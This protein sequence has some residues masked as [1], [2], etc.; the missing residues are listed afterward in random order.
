MK[1]GVIFSLFGS[2]DHYL[3]GLKQ[4][5]AVMQDIYPDSTMIVHTD[6]PERVAEALPEVEIE[7]HSHSKELAGAFW[8]FLSYNDPRFDAV[9]FRDAD[10]VVN[11]REAAAV[12]GWLASGLPLHTMLDHSCHLSGEWPVMAGMWAARKGGIPFDFNYLVKW[13]ISKKDSFQYTSDQWF[14]R[15]YIWPLIASGDGLLHC[16]EFHSKWRG[17]PWPPHV[18]YNGHVG[19]RISQ[20]L[21]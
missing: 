16:R 1:L 13:W 4:N 2:S 6:Q 9:L 20:A 3:S 11:V 15:R 17:E 12:N 18:E 19:E 10:S 7:T 14:L 21:T 5:F 8:R